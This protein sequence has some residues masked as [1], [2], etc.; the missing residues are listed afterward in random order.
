VILLTKCYFTLCA[1]HAFP[2]PNSHLYPSSIVL[3]SLAFH[4]RTSSYTPFSQKTVLNEKQYSNSR[5]SNLVPKHFVHIPVCPSNPIKHFRTMRGSA[6]KKSHPAFTHFLRSHIFAAVPV[7]ASSTVCMHRNT[8]TWNPVTSWLGDC[9]KLRHSL[10][11]APVANE[12]T[13]TSKPLAPKQHLEKST[14]GDRAYEN[15]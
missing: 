9:N 12:L 13:T 5:V 14:T 2:Q 3:S 1:L 4:F 7:L 15:L 11:H 8:L 10:L 6:P